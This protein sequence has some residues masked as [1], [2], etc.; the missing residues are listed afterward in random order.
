MTIVKTAGVFVI[1]KKLELLVA[2]PTKHDKDFWSIPKG[3]IDAGEDSLTAALRELWEESNV[4]FR[5]TDPLHYYELDTELFN[6]KRKRLKP[7]IIFE[8]ENGFNFDSFDLKCNSNVPSSRGAFPEMDDF[9]FVN[10]REIGG[11]YK[12]HHTQMSCL[13]KIKDIMCIY[14]KG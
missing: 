7:Y 13:N 11:K 5:N 6:N 2:H 12:L 14:F 4:D 8:H 1:N 3:K 10:I 9:V